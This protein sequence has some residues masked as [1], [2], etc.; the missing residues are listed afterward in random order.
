MYCDVCG[1]E[2]VERTLENRARVVCPA[3]GRVAYRQLKVGAAVLVEREGKV[4]LAR[5]G[6]DCDV[7]PG[8][9]YL[10]AGYCEA[11]EPPAAT[12]AREAWEE[13]GLRVRVGRLLDL[14][15][16][17]DDPRGNGVLA[18]YEAELVEPAGE[19]A[20]LCPPGEV[21]Q[22]AFFAADGLPEPLCGAGHDRA[23]LA[24]RERAAD[25]WQPGSLPR[26]CP[27]CARPL[28][29]REAFGRARLACPTC[30]FVHFRELK[31]GV[32]IVIQ[33]DG[34]ILLIRRDV[35]P[36]RGLWALPSGFVESDE[37][38][39]VAA[40][41][42]CHEETGVTVGDLRLVNAAYY[43]DDFR[44]PGVNLIYRARIL[45][46]GLQAGDDASDARFFARTEL[47]PRSEIAFQ[48]HADLLAD[49]R[50][51]TA[52]DGVQA[53]DGGR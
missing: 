51:W 26:F 47:P 46:G 42:E 5:R 29:E 10:P 9:W 31:V 45:G 7:Y 8:T 12:A 22:V 39:E 43:S 14:Y 2:L 28:E 24:W 37:S 50:I 1:Q 53:N 15:F 41:R 32:S 30:G 23:I 27:H 17:A 48:G 35:E 16:F 34:R 38:P 21:S 44:G 3:C 25:R 6:E 4:L 36:G 18:V 33:Q 20:P 52:T 13:T 40:C 19:P 11:D 49:D